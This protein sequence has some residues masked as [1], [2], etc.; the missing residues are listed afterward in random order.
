MEIERK[1]LIDPNALPFPLTD[2]PSHRIEQGYLCTDP[3]VR[4]RKE[5]A[6]YIL[7]YKSKGLM[8]RKEYNLPLTPEAYQ[9]L[10][11]KI[12]GKLIQKKRYFIPAKNNL[13]IELDVFEGSLS[14]LC[15][16]EVEFPDTKTADA[17][18][19][20]AWLQEEVTYTSKY[21]NSNLSK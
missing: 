16:A 2:Y 19:P 3:V 9:H 18:V 10:K 1:F 17:Y 4:I 13:T 20:P 15:L 21:H 8:V 7:T 11:A 12:D 14:P 6:E 5:E